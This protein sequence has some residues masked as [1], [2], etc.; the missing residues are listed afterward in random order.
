MSKDPINSMKV[1]KEN[2][3]SKNQTTQTTKYTYAYT[4]IDEKGY[5]T[6]NIQQIP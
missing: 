3:Q 4:L 6:Y 2:L 1:L 5:N